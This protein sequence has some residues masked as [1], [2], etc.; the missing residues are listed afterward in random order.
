M[1]QRQL[2]DGA[3]SRLRKSAPVG[4]GLEPDTDQAKLHQIKNGGILQPTYRKMGN[5][6][7]MAEK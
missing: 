2:Q 6:V 3:G 7:A 1:G 4:L 5:N